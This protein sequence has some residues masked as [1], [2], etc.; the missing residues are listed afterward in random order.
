MKV[1]RSVEHWQ[2]CSLP[3]RSMSDF[4]SLANEDQRGYGAVLKRGSSFMDS[5]QFDAELRA[6]RS[7]LLDRGNPDSFQ[8][9]N[10]TNCSQCMFC[11]G[12]ENCHGCQYSK[13]S[14]GCTQCTHVMACTQC[15]QSTHLRHSAR[16]VSSHY[17]THCDDCADCTYCFGCV[18]LVRREFHILNRPYDRPTYFKM[19]HALNAELGLN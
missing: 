15:H 18:G 5:R 7:D 8:S 12:C 2:F 10:C 14:V 13:N 19:V 6:L 11:E 9:D 1:R 3:C 17:L 4:T 16:C